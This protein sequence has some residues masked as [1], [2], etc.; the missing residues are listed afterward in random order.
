MQYSTVQYNTRCNA[1]MPLHMGKECS[2]SL[3]WLGT[4]P[5]I[6]AQTYRKRKSGGETDQEAPLELAIQEVAYRHFCLVPIPEIQDLN[7]SALQGQRCPTVTSTPRGPPYCVPPS[8]V[9]LVKLCFPDSQGHAALYSPLYNVPG[10]LLLTPNGTPGPSSRTGLP[11]DLAATVLGFPLG[12]GSYRPWAAPVPS[13]PT[14]PFLGS[15]G[16]PPSTP[17]RL[18][19]AASLEYTFTISAGLAGGARSRSRT[20]TTSLTRIFFSLIAPDA[21]PAAAAALSRPPPPAP[22]LCAAPGAPPAAPIP[23]PAA[24]AP[25]ACVPFRWRGRAPGV[26]LPGPPG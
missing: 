21:P 23:L 20:A 8:I 12:F 4:R 18:C 10:P 13:F 22:A 7:R 1:Y 5:L 26:P 14:L 3:R 19:S 17:S 16:A 25:P 24:P 15:L 2:T 11:L 9:H 6:Q